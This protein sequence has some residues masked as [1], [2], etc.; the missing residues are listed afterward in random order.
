MK[1]YTYYLWLSD[2]DSKVQYFPTE[3]ALDE[4]RNW[5]MEQLGGGSV[6]TCQWLFMH[7]DG[8]K[9]VENT[10][11]IESLWVQD[12][13]VFIDFAKHLKAYY[14]QESVLMEVSEVDARFI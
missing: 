14:N 9:I 2:K 5:V 4:V 11:K 1:K 10:I 6:S 12:E 7:D 8:T 3:S 13:K